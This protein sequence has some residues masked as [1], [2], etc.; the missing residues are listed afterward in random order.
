[1]HN[2]E[3][4]LVILV[5]EVVPVVQEFRQLYDP[6]AADGIPPHVTI[7]YPFMA[8]HTLSETTVEQLRA[9]CSEHAEFDVTFPCVLVFQQSLWLD[10]RPAEPFQALIRDACRGFPEY[11][12]YGGI[13]IEIPPHLTIAVL[14]SDA[15]RDRV[16]QTFMES[17][18]ANLPVRTRARRVALMTKRRGTWTEKA[19]FPFRN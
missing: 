7:L 1:M 17:Q 3:T 6:S 10:P 12:P 8:E 13:D 18:A 4:A 5:P 11:P 15:E 2:N 14:D 16:H 19:S 9:M